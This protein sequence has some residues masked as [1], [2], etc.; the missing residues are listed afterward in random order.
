MTGATRINVATAPL[1]MAAQVPPGEPDAAHAA[2]PARAT[3][4]A[5]SAESGLHPHSDLS[6]AT[7]TTNAAITYEFTGLLPAKTRTGPKRSR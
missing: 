7:S 6:D 4:Q 3:V 2:P 5:Q 1:A